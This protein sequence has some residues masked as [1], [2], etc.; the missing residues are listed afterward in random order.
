[1]TEDIG[2]RNN[3]GVR[4]YTDRVYIGS[5]VRDAVMNAK[6]NFKRKLPRN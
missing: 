1:M 5:L 4:M 2:S 3:N 6:E